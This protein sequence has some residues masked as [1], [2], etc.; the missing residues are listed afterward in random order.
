MAQLNVLDFLDSA[1]AEDLRPW[2]VLFG[3][4]SFLERQALQRIQ[5]LFI[6]SDE[7]PTRF[8][9]TAE[10][11]DV[12][13]ELATRSLFG[14]GEPRMVVITEADKF[15]TRNRDALEND[16]TGKRKNGL[17]VLA[18]QS[19]PSNT[20]LAKSIAKVGLTVE[21]RAP[22]KGK[23]VDTKRVLDWIQ[24]RAR[25]AHKFKL[26]AEAGRLLLELSGL[27]FGILDQNLAKLAVY[28]SG[29][30]VD[31]DLVQSAVGGWRATTAW[32]MID[33][34]LSGETGAAL[35]QWDHLIQAGE[36]PIGVFAQVSFTLRRLA[37]ATR[38]FQDARA[39]ERPMRLGDAL[40]EAGVRDW[41]AGN[42]RKSEQQL[43]RL[44]RV[45]AS[46]LFRWLLDA[47]LALKGTHSTPHRARWCI[48]NLFLKMADMKR[49]VA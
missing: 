10:W 6:A 45:R 16:T 11:R 24:Q 8:D 41:P 38:I 27:E 46:Q 28:S 35:T 18:V 23:A 7:G 1:K 31:A 44:G 5:E 14:G 3:G 25:S 34:A 48:E 20:R 9:D 33:A 42:I 4:E 2:V 12:R 32:D 21:C 19:W 26:T 37:A 47:D 22:A 30:K 17:L 40:A 39:R 29:G 36:N 13:D 15:V 43:L 49:P